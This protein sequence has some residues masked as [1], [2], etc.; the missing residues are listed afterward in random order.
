M[1]CHS[2]LL[3]K[4]LRHACLVGSHCYQSLEGV[5]C[6][7]FAVRAE[8]LTPHA[9][10]LPSPQPSMPLR[11]PAC[12]WAAQPLESPSCRRRVRAR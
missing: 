3:H 6:S 11:L 2:T 7:V 9:L 10:R 5:G 8:C 4:C 12:L 1:R